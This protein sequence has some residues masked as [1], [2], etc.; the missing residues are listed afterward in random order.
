MSIETKYIKTWE[1][2]I[3]AQK[4][5]YNKYIIHFVTIYTF[6]TKFVTNLLYNIITHIPQAINP[7]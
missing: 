5:K 4:T 1:N 3:N 7:D 6:F 2:K